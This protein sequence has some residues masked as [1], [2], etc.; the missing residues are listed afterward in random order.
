MSI[1]K[2]FSAMQLA[3]EKNNLPVVFKNDLE[4]DYRILQNHN[5]DFIWLLRTGGTVLTP[6][7][8]GVEPVYIT[9][10]KYQ[11]HGQ[12]VIPF[13]VNKSAGYIEKIAMER[14]EKLILQL[15]SQLNT[16]MSSDAIVQK[17]QSVLEEGKKKK[18]WGTFVSPD[19]EISDWS[20]WLNFFILSDNELMKVY[21]QRAMHLLKN[22]K[23]ELQSNAA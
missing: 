21:L 13:L 2:A 7:G 19:I 20:E 11:N 3:A 23:S 22:S 4:Q 16:F 8:V 12:R 18:I 17:V 14:A 6:I 5:T 1:Q 15:P 9:Y 10:W